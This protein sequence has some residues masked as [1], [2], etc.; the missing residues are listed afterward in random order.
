VPWSA[1]PKEIRGQVESTDARTGRESVRTDLGESGEQLHN[2]H[3]FVQWSLER[4][5][6]ELSD[7]SRERG[8]DLMFDLPLG[9]PPHAYDAWAWRPSFAFDVTV[10]APP[11]TFF[12]A[13]QNWGFVPQIPDRARQDRHD[14]FV[15]VVRHHLRHAGRLR[16]DHIMGLYRQYLIPDGFDAEHGVYV[17]YPFEE[18]LAILA[19][20]ASGHGALL[21]GEDLGTVPDVVR[22]QMRKRGVA[23]MY[24]LQSAFSSEDPGEDSQ[25]ADG[26]LAMVNTHDMHLFAS[27]WEDEDLDQLEELGHLS[28][29]E[30]WSIRGAR[31]VG[32]GRL[33]RSL[34]QRGLLEEGGGEEGIVA[35]HSACVRWLASSSAGFLQINLEDLWGEKRP[36]N[37]PGSGPE[38]PNWRGRMCFTLDEA[39]DL[40]EVGGLLRTLGPDPG[41]TS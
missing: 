28:R 25:P 24:V 39:A 22:D 16:M 12:R 27:W 14:Y 5:L 4:Q 13:G 34:R 9:V 23:G 11:D 19:L 20:E 1:W 31:A 18:H 8:V 2:Y 32:R 3:L 35:I 15:S 7:L 29:G 36:H 40:P 30:A 17:R 26:Q 37:I 21:V 33:L 10:G 6:S 38:L 41:A